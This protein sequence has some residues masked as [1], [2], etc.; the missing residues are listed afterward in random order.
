MVAKAANM[1][2]N[3]MQTTCQPTSPLVYGI[4]STGP[5][6]ECKDGVTICILEM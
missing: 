1:S 4:L 5:V 3:R 6:R 2:L